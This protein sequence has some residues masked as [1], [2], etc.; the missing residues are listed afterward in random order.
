M[1]MAMA[2]APVPSGP[3]QQDVAQA[4]RY[5]QD[6]HTFTA[7]YD[8]MKSQLEEARQ[9][10]A[11]STH[12]VASASADVTRLKAVQHQCRVQ[13][14]E[15]QRQLEDTTAA[16]HSR[17]ASMTELEDARATDAKQCEMLMDTMSGLKRDMEK[18]RLLVEHL[19]PHL[20]SAA[21]R[22]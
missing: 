11:T 8:I 4:Q 5:L 20:L 19:A 6:L 17:E 21:D 7:R 3:S 15:L 16:L 1:A 9:K 2:A 22:S 13:I 10:S 12:Q 14:A 18:S